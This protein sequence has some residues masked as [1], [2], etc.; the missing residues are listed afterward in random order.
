MGHK[1]QGL[2]GFFVLLAILCFGLNIFGWLNALTFIV[3]VLIAGRAAYDVQQDA[4]VREI[5][6]N[7][8]Q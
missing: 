4:A 5:A 8:R 6:D 1:A 2:F 7:T 3:A